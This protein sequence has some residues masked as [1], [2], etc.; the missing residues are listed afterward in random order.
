MQNTVPVNQHF[1]ALLIKQNSLQN[2]IPVNQHFSASLI[3]KENSLQ[4]IIPVNQHFSAS[5]IKNNQIT[6]DITWNV[7]IN[8]GQYFTVHNNGIYCG[9]LIKLIQKYYYIFSNTIYN[10]F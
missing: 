9:K 8:T 5:L 4:N 10:F 7:F 6:H 1:S 2:T 3:K